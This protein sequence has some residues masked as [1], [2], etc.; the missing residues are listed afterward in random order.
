MDIHDMSAYE[1]I[2]LSLARLASTADE[3][4]APFYRRLYELVS[5]LSIAPPATRLFG[6][7]RD[8]KPPQVWLTLK[9]SMIQIW[10]DYNDADRYGAEMPRL[11]YR[12]EFHTD[13]CKLAREIRTDDPDEVASE[14]RAMFGLRES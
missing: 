6:V 14:I 3:K 4:W 9:Q 10:P 8:S 11:H 13:G 1:S 12:I 7:V 2:G 5:R